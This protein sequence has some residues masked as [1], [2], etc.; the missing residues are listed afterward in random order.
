MKVVTIGTEAVSGQYQSQ[1]W[2]FP[3]GLIYY[4]LDRTRYEH[5]RVKRRLKRQTLK[6]VKNLYIGRLNGWLMN[7][8]Q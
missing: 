5:I 8:A 1:V 3:L 6:E 2:I 7:C 4:Q